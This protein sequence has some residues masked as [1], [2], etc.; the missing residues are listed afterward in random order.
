[1][2]KEPFLLAKI[3]KAF[4][5]REGKLSFIELFV[6][7][8]FVTAGNLNAKGMSKNAWLRLITAGKNPGRKFI[9]SQL[10]RIDKSNE[11]N[12]LKIATKNFPLR[13]SSGGGMLIFKLPNGQK[14][15]PII[16]RSEVGQHP[17]KLDLPGGMSQKI[18]E[19]LY[20]LKLAKREISEEIIIH[21]GKKTYNCKNMK[22]I[23]KMFA[24]H[25]IFIHYQ[26]HVYT[27]TGIASLDETNAALDTRN[28]Y[29]I[30][31]NNN[32]L[33]IKDGETFFDKNRNQFLKH[34]KIYLTEFNNLFKIPYRNI[35]PAFRAVLTA[36]NKN[37]KYI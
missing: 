3:D 27:Y 32:D 17:G 2:K 12:R 33:T 10:K 30:N 14:L 37:D 9:N 21:T 20:P 18:S 13:W 19:M 11:N 22:D 26:K 5:W 6:N 24:T 16:K 25:K 8:P 7:K 31:F 1:M 36:I 23:T 28:I 4:L 29:L 34:R 15:T 35:T